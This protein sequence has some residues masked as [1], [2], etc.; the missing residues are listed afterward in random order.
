MEA[1]GLLCK[2]AEG[3]WVLLAVRSMKPLQLV[4]G[5]CSAGNAF[6]HRGEREAYAG[7]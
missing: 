3:L 7:S 5:V 6:M 1:E 2:S 4:L